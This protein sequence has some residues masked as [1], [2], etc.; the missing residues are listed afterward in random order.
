MSFVQ[1][2][3]SG[4]AARGG[5]VLGG[6]RGCALALSV[7]VGTGDNPILGLESER[8]LLFWREGASNSSE[9]KASSFLFV[10]RHS[11]ALREEVW[12]PWFLPKIFF[13]PIAELFS[14][15][16]FRFVCVPCRVLLARVLS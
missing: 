4:C 1:Q 9:E 12:R 15:V 7:V 11:A 6:N 16:A 2:G 13:E 10:C 5:R 14:P 3:R 8:V